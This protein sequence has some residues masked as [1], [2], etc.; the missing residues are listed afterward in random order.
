L[1]VL[2]D[3]DIKPV[4][5]EYLSTPP[6][7]DTLRDILDM[8]GLRPRELMRKK[9]S[10]EHGLDDPSFSDDE[11]IAKMVANPT[12]IERPIVVHNGKARIGRPPECVL[13]I[14]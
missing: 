10:A 9:E 3:N 13:E 6:D 7:A 2:H 4:V 8:L 11:I 1:Q 14:L 12:V 5:I